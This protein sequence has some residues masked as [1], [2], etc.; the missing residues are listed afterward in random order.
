M[1]TLL[2]DIAPFALPGSLPAEVRFEEPRDIERVT[3]TL[4]GPCQTQPTLQYLRNTWPQ[5]R[6][7]Y[8]ADQDLVQPGRFGWKRMDDWFN[9]RWVD[10]ATR[11]ECLSPR[12]LVFTFKGLLA[13]IDEFPNARQYDVAF[14]RTLGIR[15]LPADAAIRGIQVYTRSPAARTRLRVEL[16]AGHKTP[17]KAIHISGYNAYIRKVDASRGTTARGSEVRLGSARTRSFEVDVEHMAPAHRWC[18]DDGLVTFALD[19]ETFTISL[20][21]L[22]KEGPIW[23]AEQGM[24]IA[25]RD[26]ATT[27][28]DYRARIAGHK[29]IARQVVEQPEQSLAGARNGQ[30]RPHPVPYCFGCKHARQKFWLEPN[31]DLVLHKWLLERQP[32]KDTPR[33]KNAGDA[34]FFFGLGRWSVNGRFNDPWP[35]MAYNMGLKQGSLLLEQKCFAVPLLGS[36]L[37]RAET[38]ADETIVALVRLRFQNTGTEADRAQISLGYS[39]RSMRSTN[40]RLELQ[41]DKRWQDDEL[42]PRG[43]RDLLQFDG[44]R[45]RS[46]HEGQSVI[47]CTFETTMH[48]QTCKTGLQFE[49]ELGPGQSCELL[50]KIP[51]VSVETDEELAG[52]AALDFARCYEEMKQYWLAE[53]RKGAGIHTPEP[54]LNGVYAGHL[55]MVLLSDFGSPDGSTLVN[56]SVGAATYGNY[57]NESCMILEELDQRGLVE[58][59]RR[60]LGV[61]VKHQGTAKL[62]GNFTDYDGLLYGAGGMETGDSYNQ[63]HGWALWYLAQHYLLTGNSAWFAGVADA[64]LAGARWIFRQRRNTLDALPHSRGWERGFLPAGALED[65][66]DYFYW[67]ST[68]AFTWRGADAAGRALERFGH[69][70]AAGIRREANRYRKD[71]IRGLET[72]RKYSPVIRLADGR[73]IP[74]YPSRLYRRGRDFGWIREVLEGSVNLLI[75][76]LYDPASRQGRWILDD[77]QDTRYRNPPLDYVMVDPKSEWFDCGGFSPQ[78]TLL[79]GLLPYLDRDEPELYIWMFFNA[80]AACYREE[81][82]ALVEHPL[83]VLGFSNSAPFKT[84]DQSNATKWLCRMFV[85]EREDLLHLGRAIPREWLVEGNDIHARRVATRFGNVSVRYRSQNDAKAITAEVDFDARRAPDRFLVRF[86]HPERLQIRSVLVNGNPGR[87]SDIHGEDVDISGMKGNLRITARY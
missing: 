16:D 69:P 21:S 58:E 54:H 71:L 87:T 70:D 24:Y 56:T 73:W 34:R 41:G 67:L 65:V 32:G 27:F 51:Y 15:L 8:P 14:R 28:A 17:G 10:A 52:L 30:P 7:E 72:S 26:D 23:F 36:I 39:G 75:S 83:P 86:R 84:S 77:Y 60:R 79:A 25:R 19:K 20:T 13:E 40:R 11:I 53:G 35:T 3:V 48:V 49:Q 22:E 5:D 76:G 37:D 55:P 68:N 44:N 1:K 47:R 46:E 64:V 61:W 63:H 80:F 42:V 82:N 33:W 59:V 12:R 2:F 9:S 85:Y 81:I 6:W 4:A 62:R 50:L 66:A 38:A 18:H 29:T 78:P 43:P 57:T 31:G 74:H 45:I